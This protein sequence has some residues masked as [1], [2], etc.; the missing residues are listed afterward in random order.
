MKYKLTVCGGTFDLLHKGHKDFLEEILKVSEK[1]FLG[2]TSDKYVQIHKSKHGIASFEKRK[3][4]LINFFEQI[5]AQDRVEVKAI[6][7]LYGPLLDLNFKAD[8]LAV[9]ADTYNSALEIN[10]KRKE[11]S[12]SV[13]EIIKIPM[14]RDRKGE[15]LSTTRIKQGYINRGGK[16]I[17]PLELR[18]EF[19][20][21][22]GKL[23]KDIPDNIDPSKVI[24]V[25]DVTTDKFLKKG[26]TPKLAVV[27]FL[28]NR[29]PIPHKTFN[30][31]VVEANNPAGTISYE[32]LEEV[33][34][35]FKNSSSKVMIVHGEEDL[36]VLPALI[37]SP[38]GSSIFYGQ[39]GKGLVRVE[40][41]KKNKEKAKKLLDKFGK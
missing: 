29:K 27:D 7:D 30:T 4:D 28:I 25:G 34:S 12:L 36:S 10:L 26:L 41:N 9:T 21:P 8:A 35:S 1:V 6:D 15:V 2:L 24:T 40:V 11:K 20:R 17:L 23:L 13:V 14:I 5:G 18:K 3:R 32:L 31:A 33:K 19:Q 39:P 38:I 16:L 37:F 22:F